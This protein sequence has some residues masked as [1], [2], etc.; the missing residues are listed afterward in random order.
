LS[1]FWDIFSP[2]NHIA[3]LFSSNLVILAYG[4][5]F[6]F[7]KSTIGSLRGG[8]LLESLSVITLGVVGILESEPMLY[9]SLSSE[10]ELQKKDS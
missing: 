8:T 5:C 10:E 3:T 9:F 6:S 2:R 1:T 7:R 4:K